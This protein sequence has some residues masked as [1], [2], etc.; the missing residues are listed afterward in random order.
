MNELVKQNDKGQSVTTSLIVA[1]IFGKRHDHVLRDIQVM[2]CSENFR[3]ANFG[4]TPYT[5]PQ[6]GQTYP[7][8]EMTKDGFSFLVMGYTGE[9]AGQFKETFINEF[10]KRDS[11]L[12]NDDFI[13]SEAQRIL[14]E[15]VESFKIQLKQKDERLKLQAHEIEMAAPKVEYHDNVLQSD[16]AIAITVIAN[17]LGMSA[18]SLNAK[19]KLL[20]VIRKVNGVYVLCSKYQGYG[21]DKTKTVHFTRSN[22]ETATKIELYWTEKGRQFIHGLLKAKQERA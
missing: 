6:N 15:R 4:E 9:K 17:D 1:E 14:F 3:L 19:L 13:L 21:Y 11:L 18:Q 22:G 20:Q 12:K 8:F 5:H 2:N 7:M 10:N 16:S